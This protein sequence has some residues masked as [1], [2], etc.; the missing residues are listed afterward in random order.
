MNSGVRLVNIDVT[1]SIIFLLCKMKFYN[2]YNS[3]E[4][5]IRKDMRAERDNE[6]N[7]K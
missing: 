5:N 6:H 2:D 7:K 1:W 3:H 4:N